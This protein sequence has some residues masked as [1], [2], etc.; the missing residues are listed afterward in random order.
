[1][2]RLSDGLP[3]VALDAC[4]GFTKCVDAL[5]IQQLALTQ[6]LPSLQGLALASQDAV[7]TTINVA[8]RDP[9]SRTV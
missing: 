3:Q 6:Q 7:N 2:A 8:T 1:M 4:E 9:N 5:V